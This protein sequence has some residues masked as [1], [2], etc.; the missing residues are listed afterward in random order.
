MLRSPRLARW[1]GAGGVLSAVAVISGMSQGR[2]AEEQAEG[3]L[4]GTALII[5]LGGALCIGLLLMAYGLARRE[6]RG[7]ELAEG[8]QNKMAAQLNTSVERQLKERAAKRNQ[9]ADALLEEISRRVEAEAVLR[10]K[11]ERLGRLAAFVE[12]SPD[13][14]IGKSLE[15]IITSWNPAAERLFGYTSA[16]AVGQPMTFLVAPDRI[17]EEARI[18]DQIRAGESV[19]H[20]ETVRQRKDGGLIDVSVSIS[21]VRDAFGKIIGASSIARDISEQKQVLGTLERMRAE[22]EQ[23]VAERTASLAAAE[24]AARSQTQLL[25]TVFDAM[26]EG[27]VMV[28]SAGRITFAN[29]RMS[30]LFGFEHN[31]LLGQSIE[32]LLPER[33]RDSHTQLRAGF[34]AQPVTRPMGAARGLVGR[35]KDGSEVLLEIALN[36]VTIQK[37]PFV[38]AS[39]IDVTERQ[40]AEEALR[41]LAAI[42]E[43]SDDAIIGITLEGIITS[44]NPAATRLLG[45]RSDEIIGRPIALLIPADRVEEEAQV[46]GRIQRGQR[47]ANFEAG[48][49]CKDG[50]LIDMAITISP[51]VDASGRVA[52][53]SMIA[54]DITDRKKAAERISA[55]LREKDALLREIHHRVKNNMQV[56]SSLLQLQ[57]AHLHDPKLL[58]PFK[59]C[60]D[61]IRTMALIHEKLY[62][63]EGLAQIDFKEYLESLTDMLLRAH[64]KGPFIRRQLNLEPVAL[65]IDLAI[66]VGLIANELIS[67]SLKHAF[68]G[69]QK[70]VVRVALTRPNQD[71]LRLAVSDDGQ[72]LPENF[73]QSTSLG[74]RLVR[75][76]TGQINGR[77]EYKSENG[78]EFA[79][80]FSTTGANVK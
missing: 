25:E 12:S 80:V 16:E 28:D 42:V 52:G 39:I 67:N 55:S 18:L 35:R 60:Q 22:L 71:E 37:E 50:R 31:E 77:M 47:V 36:P 57:S 1:T 5:G 45:Y 64:S 40:R 68:N 15:G 61:R 33:S 63:T 79:I 10:E 78:A 48:R 43:S 24:A 17:E 73:L 56:V 2:L 20:F 65:S 70:G 8:R 23:G 21:P 3:G 11:V 13:A 41:C 14:I 74:V 59:D 4:G 51:I 46:L 6:M 69:R 32:L 76:L 30:T 26:G 34:M 75:I 49:H 66:P 62:R 72:G 54:R 7:R 27:M 29:R 19:E 44:W 9:R 53:A 38:L 58:E